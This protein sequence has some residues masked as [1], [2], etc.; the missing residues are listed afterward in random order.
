[1]DGILKQIVRPA[2]RRGIGVSQDDKGRWGL[3]AFLTVV[4]MYA[5]VGL[6]ILLIGMYAMYHYYG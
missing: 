5:V 3:R 1:M 4:G 2:H 6:I